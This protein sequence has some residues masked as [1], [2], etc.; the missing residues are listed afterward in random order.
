MSK[1]FPCKATTEAIAEH[2]HI[3]GH[4]RSVPDAHFKK[5]SMYQ[6]PHRALSLSEILINGNVLQILSK[7]HSP[8]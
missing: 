8:S 2:L 7:K 1:D 5:Q 6:P 3:L 4:D